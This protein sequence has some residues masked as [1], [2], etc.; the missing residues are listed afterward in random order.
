LSVSASCNT[1]SLGVELGLFFRTPHFFTLPIRLNNA[2][3]PEW[4]GDGIGSPPLGG[5]C[6]S[7]EVIGGGVEG[8][9]GLIG[10]SSSAPDTPEP[11]LSIRG[12]AFRM[13]SSNTASAGGRLFCLDLLLSRSL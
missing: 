2:V 9:V 5:E 3:F 10:T 1:T 13:L 6:G 11:A 7:G 4:E 12:R 8:A